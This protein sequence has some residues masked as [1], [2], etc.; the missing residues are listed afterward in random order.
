M[1]I[2]QKKNKETRDSIT[3]PKYGCINIPT[4]NY[5]GDIFSLLIKC[6]KNN[7][8]YKNV[9]N[10][11]DYIN[12]SSNNFK[13]VKCFKKITISDSFDYCQD[14][15][16]IFDIKCIEDNLPHKDMH[17][18]YKF[19]NKNFYNYCLNHF[20]KF[21]YYCENC[22]YS[23]CIN[24]LRNNNHN[25]HSLIKL[26]EIR[27]D[28]NKLESIKKIIEEQENLFI[29]VK[30]IMNDV[31]SEFE[32]DL[33][34]KKLIYENYINHKRNYNSIYNIDKLFFNIN[35]EYKSK[36]NSLYDNDNKN[37]K[38]SDNVKKILSIFYYYIMLQ[39]KEKENKIL[40][41]I[42][43]EFNLIK[44]NNNIS[45]YLQ[46]MKNEEIIE[47]NNNI[48]NYKYKLNHVCNLSKTI[49]TIIEEKIITSVIRI[50]SGNL[51]MGF[52]N[53]LI[54][55]YNSL[56]LCSSMQGNEELLLIDKFKGRKINYLYELN[57]NTLLCSTYSKIYKIKLKNNDSQYEYLS[58]IKLPN[59]ECP[60]RIISLGNELIVCLTQ[61]NKK[62]DNK[63]V[64]ECYLRIYKLNSESQKDEE[65][66]Y[67]SDYENENYN[68]NSGE[69]FFSDA[70]S[71]SDLNNIQSIDSNLMI[72][73]NI[74]LYKKNI[75]DNNKYICSI[76]GTKIMSKSNKNNDNLFEFISTSNTKIENANGEDKIYFYGV[77]KSLDGHH[78]LNF[79]IIGEIDQISCSLM[80]ESICKINNNYIGVAIQRYRNKLGE[81]AVINVKKKEI[82]F[83]FGN[84]PIDL[85]TISCN[86]NILIC[87]VN[88]KDDKIKNHNNLIKYIKI[89]NIIED[90]KKGFEFKK[91]GI[92]IKFRNHFNSIVELL[93]NDSQI[94]NNNYFY[95]LFGNNTFFI[96][97]I[98]LE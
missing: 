63:K 87:S 44:E 12:Q 27:P 23:L 79:K 20:Q 9:I 19:N 40:N 49:K 55:V 59:Y 88:P 28:M 72:D 48:K 37:L 18:I 94:K 14:C 43:N 61:R 5:I 24:C 34:L 13:C 46:E 2:F 3:C 47:K 58:K 64:I 83:I 81:Y 75:R 56:K 10:I 21:I 60:K 45:N 82:K 97:R 57:D 25:S 39:N 74:I 22:N 15:N 11:K 67:L 29:K 84:T 95:C 52:R 53:G 51:V 30:K 4:I 77:N 66:G 86:K 76:F 89:E 92:L 33:K 90:G 38:T 70:S 65:I 6:N 68:Y 62:E 80:V 16:S 17:S 69:E 36:I 41:I 35:E 91:N 78:R 8:N 31:I 98:D 42:R 26:D 71:L 93:P 96:I 85:L 73:S 54:K 7:C 50:K 32:N 1:L